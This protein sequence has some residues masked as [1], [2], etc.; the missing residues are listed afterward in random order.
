MYNGREE[1]NQ[2]SPPLA[3]G[4]VG[5]T[6]RGTRIVSYYNLGRGASLVRGTYKWRGA[7][8]MVTIILVVGSSSL[9]SLRSVRSVRLTGANARDSMVCIFCFPE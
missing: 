1:I 3:E 4:L 8:R 7:A 6:C 9:R 5:G 2:E